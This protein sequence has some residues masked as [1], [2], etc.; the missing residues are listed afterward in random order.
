MDGNG[1]NLV[2]NVY[3]GLRT[4]T[5]IFLMPCIIYSISSNQEKLYRFGEHRWVLY[6]NFSW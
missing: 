1:D 6:I 4:K 3:N 2:Q 5:N